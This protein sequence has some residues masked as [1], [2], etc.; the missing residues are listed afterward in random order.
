MNRFFLISIFLIL[1]IVALAQASGGQI[2]RPTVRTEKTVPPRNIGQRAQ[3]TKSHVVNGRQRAVLRTSEQNYL[4]AYRLR[5]S[6]AKKAVE[7]FLK[8]YEIGEAPYKMEALYQLGITYYYGFNNV[9]QDYIKALPYFLSAVEFG[10]NRS[11][12]YLGDCYQY[13]KGCKEDNNKADF[14]KKASGYTSFPN[15]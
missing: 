8:A 5:S 11:K 6:D 10:D 9:S 7:L 14:W 3:V 4:E 1:P 2:H 12:Y 13:G 15:Y